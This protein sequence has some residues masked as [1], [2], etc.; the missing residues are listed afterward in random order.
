MF[1]GTFLVALSYMLHARIE[2]KFDTIP[3]RLLVGFLAF[4]QP[5]GRGWARYFTW[6]KYKRDARRRHRQAARPICQP[7]AH[8]GGI[9]RLDFWNETGKGREQLLDGNLRAARDRRLAL[10]RGH[11]LEELG[12]ADLRQPFL[13]RAASAP[14]PN[15]T[16][17]RSASPACGSESARSPLT[18]LVNVLVL[19]VLLYRQAFTANHDVVWW[20]L[21]AFARASS[22]LRGRRLKRRVADLVIARRAALRADARLRR[23]EQAGAEGRSKV[24]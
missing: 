2:P 17:A 12:R 9:T 6:M 19:C 23:G 1:L 8:R 22:A 21:Y 15:T 3:A 24:Q 20:A 13:E 4:M 10:L 16:A 7:A 5:L 14:S 11:R 18:V